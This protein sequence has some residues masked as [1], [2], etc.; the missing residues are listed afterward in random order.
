MGRPEGK[1][2]FG[3][4]KC[5]CKD[6]IKMDLLR[7]GVGAWAGLIWLGLGAAGGCL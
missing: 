1:G 2:T 5:S 7:L 6:N 4:P 3:K